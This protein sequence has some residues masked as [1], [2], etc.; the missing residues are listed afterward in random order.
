M[1]YVRPSVMAERRDSVEIL[2][3]VGSNGSGKSLLAV[4][5]ALRRMR[6]GVRVLS[7]VRLVDPDSEELC[8]DDT[9]TYKLHPNH[10]RAHPL[11][12]PL[13]NFQQLID[14]EDC[15]VL[16]D[17][18][19]GVASSRE[20]QGLPGEVGDR[21]MRFRASDVTVA[22]TSPSWARA[23]L[24]LREVTKGV[25]LAKGL[26]RR[27]TAGHTWPAAT[28]ISS[29]LVDARD[30]DELTQA[31]RLGTSRSELHSLGRALQRVSRID[32]RNAY[33][34]LDSVNTLRVGSSR[35]S[36]LR[37]GGVRR[38]PRCECG[39]E[40]AAAVARCSGASV[41]ALPQRGVAS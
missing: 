17:E 25:V 14:A 5:D 18:I 15:H 32:G 7:T 3:F 21:M 13:T 38:Q 12:E 29:R 8:D 11:W 4:D 1:V 20:S 16:L 36:C 28:W 6:R 30:L 39:A 41:A 9:C 34:T 19:T 40:T 27:A 33:H 22:W 24:L 26:R 35:G 31:Q 23:D 2:A 10:R 37:C